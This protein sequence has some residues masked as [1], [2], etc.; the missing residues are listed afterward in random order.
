MGIFSH[1]VVSP[2]AAS[3]RLARHDK[4]TGSQIN[5]NKTCLAD[6]H[7]VLIRVKICWVFDGVQDSPWLVTPE[8][9]RLSGDLERL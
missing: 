5:D 4:I 2:S 1:A 9:T 8:A 3:N 6:F 7:R